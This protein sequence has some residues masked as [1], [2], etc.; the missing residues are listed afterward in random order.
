MLDDCSENI[1]KNGVAERINRAL[2]ESFRS[3]SA[4]S[5]LVIKNIMTGRS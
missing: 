1:T 2:I 3:V 4:D 5:E